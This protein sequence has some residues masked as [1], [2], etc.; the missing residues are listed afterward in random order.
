[1]TG[2]TVTLADG[3]ALTIPTNLTSV[4]RSDLKPGASVKASYEDKSGQKVVTS[5]EVEPSR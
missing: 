5:I 3:T 1:V 2:D 4:R